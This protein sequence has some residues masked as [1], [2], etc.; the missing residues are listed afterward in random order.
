MGGVRAATYDEAADCLVWDYKVLKESVLAVEKEEL[1][2]KLEEL[3][4]GGTAIG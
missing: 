3:S 2:K 1:K 4:G